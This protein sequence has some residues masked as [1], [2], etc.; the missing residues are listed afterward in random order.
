LYGQGKALT[1]GKCCFPPRLV[2]DPAEGRSGDSHL[3]GG[4]ILNESTGVYQPEGFD[5]IES[6]AECLEVPPRDTGG[7]EQTHGEVGCHATGDLWSWH[8]II[9]SKCSK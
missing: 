9:M 4:G 3:A 1:Q 7:F 6:Q 2:Q 8:I 5:F